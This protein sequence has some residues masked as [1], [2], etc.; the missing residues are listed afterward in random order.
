ML[1]S[2]CPIN[3][4][5][6]QDLTNGRSNPPRWSLFFPP[7]GVA[8]NPQGSFQT[9]SMLSTKPCSSPGSVPQLSRTPGSQGPAPFT[10]LSSGSFLQKECPEPQGWAWTPAQ[11]PPFPMHLV[12]LGD[13]GSFPTDQWSLVGI[14]ML[15]RELRSFEPHKGRSRAFLHLYPGSFF[16]PCERVA[17]LPSAASAW[18][19]GE[20][21]FVVLFCSARVCL[22]LIPS[23]ECQNREGLLLLQG[24][25]PS[26][27]PRTEMETVPAAA[28]LG[29]LHLIL[30]G[31][32]P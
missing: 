27:P 9:K 8:H 20:A 19:L 25:G 22:R 1:N 3:C 11:G 28:T 24:S 2:P 30:E 26:P 16:V 21:V 31:K 18:I 32:A 4:R 13:P 29:L 12:P 5:P 23:R 6:P 14:A 17:F 7:H 10:L 15:G